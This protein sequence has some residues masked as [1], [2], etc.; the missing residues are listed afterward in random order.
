MCNRAIKRC[1]GCAKQQIHSSAHREF[2]SFSQVSKLLFI[3][4]CRSSS[5]TVGARY[6]FADCGPSLM[7]LQPHT[8]QYELSRPG[9][10]MNSQRRSHASSRASSGDSTVHH[11]AENIRLVLFSSILMEC[12]SFSSRLKVDFVFSR[13]MF[14]V[15]NYWRGYGAWCG[16]CLSAWSRQPHFNF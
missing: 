10:E 11:L 12:Y 15:F 9:P 4:R 16:G 1:W 2:P 5:A 7:D 8:V 14:S 3:K 6:D 13:G